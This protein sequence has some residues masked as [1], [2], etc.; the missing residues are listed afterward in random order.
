MEEEDELSVK[1]G[2]LGE[3]VV[4]LPVGLPVGVPAGGLVEPLLDRPVEAVLLV[5]VDFVAVFLLFVRPFLAP[6]TTVCGVPLG[7]GAGA[8]LFFAGWFC[9][10]S[11]R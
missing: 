4:C 9:F 5:G 10:G 6:A 11:V 2:E 8:L 1:V 3:V 7:V